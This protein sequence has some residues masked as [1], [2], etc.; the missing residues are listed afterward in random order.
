MSI[1]QKQPS[2]QSLPNHDLQSMWYQ[3]EWIALETVGT[4]H[5]WVRQLKQANQRS[6]PWRPAGTV[7]VTD[8]TD[9]I[10]EQVALRLAR[11]GAQH[12]VL[13]SEYGANSPISHALTSELVALGADVTILAC[14]MTDRKTVIALLSRLEQLTAVVHTGGTANAA[15]R[16]TKT[17]FDEFTEVVSTKTDSYLAN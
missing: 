9:L 4:R 3:V 12:L 15:S 13:T 2:A 5:N 7:L 6:L 17:I 16:L 10:G 11:N 1:T 14:D 8:G